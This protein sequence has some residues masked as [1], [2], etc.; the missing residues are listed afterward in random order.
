MEPILKLVG[1][2]IY[3]LGQL[4]SSGLEGP[5]WASAVRKAERLAELMDE[6]IKQSVSDIVD[7]LKD[8][9]NE[10][11]DEAIGAATKNYL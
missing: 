7:D 1:T 4:Q 10:A 3:I 11:T 8:V 2:E 5:E 9:V 6:R